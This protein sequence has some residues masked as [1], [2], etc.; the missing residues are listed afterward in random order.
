MLP[1]FKQLLAFDFGDLM[2]G[3]K[4]LLGLDIGSSAV[5]AIQ[6]KE[7]KGRYVLEKFGIKPLEP[8]VIVDGS[9]MD[10]GRV[11]SAMPSRN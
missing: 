2:S 11:I 8:E 1:D 7:T 4:Q 3:K 6:M 5:K 10:E 9:V